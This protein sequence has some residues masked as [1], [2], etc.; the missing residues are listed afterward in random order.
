M[1]GDYFIILRRNAMGIA[2]VK[3]K[4]FRGIVL[5]DLEDIKYFF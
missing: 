4:P 2:K 5:Q 1:S 3:Y